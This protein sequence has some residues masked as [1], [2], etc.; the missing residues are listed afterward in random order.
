VKL[1]TGAR[2]CGACG[3]QLDSAGA[4]GA[5]VSSP[6]GTVH[7]SQV[8]PDTLSRAPMTLIGHMV[9]EYRVTHFVGKGGMGW[10]FAAVH[11]IIGKKVAIKVLKTTFSHELEV[12]N[13]FVNEAKAANA[14]GSKKIV[15]IFAFGQLPAGNL[16]FVM[17][18][19]EGESMAQYLFREGRLSF[20][21]ARLIFPLM[22]EALSA[23]HAHGI[24]HRDLKPENIFLITHKGNPVDLRLLDFGIAKF[25]A[26]QPSFLRTQAGIIKGT[27]LYMSPEQ[28]RAADT[29]AASDIYSLGIILYQAFTGR[30]PFKS[31]SYGELIAAHLSE[32]PEEPSL[33]TPM[34]PALEELILDCLQ[35]DPEKR[36]ASADEVR[37]RLLGL[38]DAELSAPA[39]LEAR[40]RRRFRRVL[41]TAVTVTLVVA[42][43]LTLWLWPRTQ[44]DRI[45]HS[46]PMPP[47]RHL[48]IVTSH[49]PVVNAELASG[50][51]F[52]LAQ[53]GY[54]PVEIEW[55]VQKDD[56][57]YIRNQLRS[58]ILQKRTGE[59][60]LMIGGGESLHR[61]LA[62]QDCIS[63]GQVHEACSQVAIEPGNLVPHVPGQLAGTNLYDPAGYW[64]GV[65]LSGFGIVC[66]E[67]A[68]EKLGL[69]FPATWED[70]ADPRF[71]QRV[72]AADPRLSSSTHMVFEMILQAYPWNDA[73]RIIVGLGANM[74]DGWLSSS[75]GVLQKI[76]DEPEIACGLAIDYFFHLEKDELEKNSGARLRFAIP[77]KTSYLTPDPVSVLSRAPSLEPARLFLRYLFTEGQKLWMLPK[78]SKWGPTHHSVPR[79]AVDPSLYKTPEAFVFYMDPFASNPP[80]PFESD[81]AVR[82]KSLLSILLQAA[83]V[84]NHRPLKEA[85]QFRLEKGDLSAKMKRL[86]LPVSEEQ[87]QKSVNS[88]LPDVLELKNLENRW[89]NDFHRVYR[90]MGRP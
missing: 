42:G 85:W 39:R 43:A 29:T 65:T 28:C 23:A 31:N 74:R 5:Q 14:I 1:E 37:S 83:V 54:P 41:W 4:S 50:F 10:V 57:G 80:R 46:I 18:L 90:Q 47:A 36:P 9:G 40:A 81:L 35:K 25:N 21:D 66:N 73:W 64:Y 79:L 3:S 44:V 12:A 38:L 20:A 84:L 78:G 86:V 88:D 77:E 70:L 13:A 53:F 48:R 11:P 24:V 51:S 69:A 59:L 8:T 89:M 16:Y 6:G 55:I 7:G 62:R 82:R 75:Q 71:F 15:D 34:P 49:P 87:F 67:K 19:L 32:E 27:P 22:L 52:W 56:L 30:V 63:V 61:T 68:L 76:V 60:D 17:E 45:L 2:F 33:L 26:E 58:A 72:I